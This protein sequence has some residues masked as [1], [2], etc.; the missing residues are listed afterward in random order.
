MDK[1]K[2]E[3]CDVCGEDIEGIRKEKRALMCSKECARAGYIGIR[4]VNI[5]YQVVQLRKVHRGNT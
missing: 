4:L 5:E 3:N 2:A 1:V